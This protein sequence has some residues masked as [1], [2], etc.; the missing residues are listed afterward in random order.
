MELLKAKVGS[1]Q[2][3]GINVDETQLALILLANIK[4]AASEDFGR[5][6]RPALQTICRRFPYNFVHDATSLQDMLTELAG[7][8]AVR[9]LKDAPHQWSS[10]HGL[11]YHYLFFFLLVVQ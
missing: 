4:T 2:S 7:V 9:K 3:Y 10:L 11:F 5:E 6:F 1:M 8:D